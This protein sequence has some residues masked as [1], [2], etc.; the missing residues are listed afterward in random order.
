M[1]MEKKPQKKQKEKLKKP[2]QKVLNL[3][4]PSKWG[5][6]KTLASTKKGF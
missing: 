4:K 3:N 1:K 5:S 2:S 6:G